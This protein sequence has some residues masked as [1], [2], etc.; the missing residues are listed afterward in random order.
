[1]QTWQITLK[2][3]LS[4]A[5]NLILQNSTQRRARKRPSPP[6]GSHL[7]GGRRAVR[8]TG[9]AFQRLGSRPHRPDDLGDGSPRHHSRLLPKS[10]TKHAAAETRLDDGCSWWFKK[11]SDVERLESPSAR[12]ARRLVFNDP[13]SLSVRHLR[14]ATAERPF[15]KSGTDGSNPVPSSGQSV[16]RGK[17]RAAVENPAFRAGVRA[18]GGA[19]VGRDWDRSAIWRLPATMSPRGQIPVPQCQ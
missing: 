3:R 7:A 15:R 19:T 13:S 9:L 2:I 17:E 8:R 6:S 1:M 18:M 12:L 10:A 16:S 4:T 14:S 5:S 11:I